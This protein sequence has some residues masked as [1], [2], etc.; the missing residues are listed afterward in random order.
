[1]HTLLAY[2]FKKLR[3]LLCRAVVPIH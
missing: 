2:V 3:S 1:M